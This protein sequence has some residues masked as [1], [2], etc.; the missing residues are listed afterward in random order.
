MKYLG[1]ICAD[2]VIEQLP[3]A[4]A[5]KHYQD[6]GRVHRGDPPPVTI[7]SKAMQAMMKTDKIDIEG[8]QRAVA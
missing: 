6:Y 8:L 7:S 2:T 5:R 4:D 3:E 1:P